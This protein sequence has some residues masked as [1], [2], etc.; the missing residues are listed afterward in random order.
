MA[1]GLGATNNLATLGEQ[2]STSADRS[3]F[4][5]PTRQLGIWS[6]RTILAL[7]VIYMLVTV[8]TRSLPYCFPSRGQGNGS[9]NQKV[10]PW[11][12]VLLTPI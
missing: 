4:T 11:P 3:D 12:G 9:V 5:A 7:G 6:A 10:A 2:K 1:T 8:D